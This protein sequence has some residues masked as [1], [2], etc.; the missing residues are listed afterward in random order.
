MH[1]LGDVVG[2]FAFGAAVVAVAVWTWRVWPKP[3]R[4]D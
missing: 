4:G 2:G 1:W 3:V